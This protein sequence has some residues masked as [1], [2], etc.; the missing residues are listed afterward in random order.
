MDELTRLPLAE[1]LDRIAA[2]TPTPG[3][4]SVAAVAGALSCALA[5]MV[6][7][8]SR[9]GKSPPEAVQRADRAVHRLS[10][11]QQ[12]LS[13]LVTQDAI[14]YGA[15]N[16]AMKAFKEDASTIGDHHEAV[17][18]ALTVPM[19][20][21]AVASNAL[22]TM[23][24]FKESAPR[25]MLSDLA[26]AATLAEAS[27]RSANY[28]VRANL[29]LLSDAEEGQRFQHEIG[30]ILGHCRASLERIEAVVRGA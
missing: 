10:A 27:A 3:G 21:A 4:G 30:E 26:I 13:V 9:N 6:A 15:L 1:F 14:V 23:D 7:T 2:R 29:A 17:R 25:W 18:A 28:L 8:Y 24:E 20:V 5:R 19:E 16:N 11:A 12:L 22:A